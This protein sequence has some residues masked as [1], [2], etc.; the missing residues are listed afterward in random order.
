LLEGQ[1]HP[2]QTKD[3][4]HNNKIE[5][6]SCVTSGRI[7]HAACQ[8]L[9]LFLVAEKFD[10]GG[11]LQHLWFKGLLEGQKQLCQNTKRHTAGT[12]ISQNLYWVS[13]DTVQNLTSEVDG[14][15]VVIS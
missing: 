10:N 7:S 12:A 4:H 8:N 2:C 11:L 15:E 5:T 3:A 6:W 9:L 14:Q 1:K 13:L